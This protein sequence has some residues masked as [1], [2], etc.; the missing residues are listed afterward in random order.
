MEWADFLDM[1]SPFFIVPAYYLVLKLDDKQKLNDWELGLFFIFSTTF[2]LAHG[3][4]L[5]ATSIGHL[6]KYFKFT[7]AYTLTYFYDELLS[8]QLMNFAVI[9]ISI[10]SCQR[11]IR[12]PTIGIEKSLTNLY[13]GGFF[14]FL[15]FLGFIEGQ[16]WKV[17]IFY[18]VVFSSFIAHTQ[19]SSLRSLPVVAFYTTA[20]SVSLLLTFIW[21]LKWG[22]LPEFSA[23]GWI[24]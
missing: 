5:A 3:I 8:H 22:A 11:Q 2:I 24:K 23:V 19:R 21:Y 20:Y 7:D 18:A 15:Y 10:L 16:T 14:G 9:G 13:L 12:L 6:L 4:H 1:F 17:S